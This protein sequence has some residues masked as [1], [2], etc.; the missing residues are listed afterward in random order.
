[1]KHKLTLRQKPWNINVGENL[2]N[3]CCSSWP[4]TSAPAL[5][6]L[7]YDVLKTTL[8]CKQ[9]FQPHKFLILHSGQFLSNSFGVLGVSFCIISYFHQVLSLLMC[10]LNSQ[11]LWST[12][13]HRGS[14]LHLNVSKG[15]KG[16]GWD[17]YYCTLPWFLEVHVMFLFIIIFT[18][19]FSHVLLLTETYVY[20]PIE[21]MKLWLFYFVFVSV[22]DETINEDSLEY[23]LFQ[24]P[25]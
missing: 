3:S 1:M 6:W 15:V 4:L 11:C 23:D 21:C 12:S 17:L 2:V 13:S 9:H 5:S 16:W 25:N 8:T 22:L 20:T 7:F 19:L 18:S 10:C 24:W 14:Y